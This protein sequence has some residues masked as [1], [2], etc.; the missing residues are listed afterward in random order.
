M[1]CGVVA[2][3]AAP[4]YAAHVNGYDSV[5]GGEVRY[6]NETVYD[7]T[8]RWALDAWNAVGSVDFKP[9]GALTNADLQVQDRYEDGADW[10]GLYK[11]DAGADEIYFNSAYF[12]GYTYDQRK[13]VAT[14]E[15]GHALGLADHTST[16]WHAI[17]YDHATA[18]GYTTP[19]AHDKSDYASL[20]G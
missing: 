7:G 20:W 16:S 19:Q 8:L 9:D 10:D 2:A 13:A 6:E 4:S 1:T 5:D 15:L 3:T 11:N 12:D 18:T 17:M 14:H